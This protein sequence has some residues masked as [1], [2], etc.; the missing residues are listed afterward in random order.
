M[1]TRNASIDNLR[2]LLI[3]LVV[4]GHVFLGLELF[5][6]EGIIG[7]VRVVGTKII[8]GFHMPAFFALSGFFFRSKAFS[9]IHELWKVIRHKLITLGI[10]YVLCSIAYWG[11]KYVLSNYLDTPVTIQQ[12]LHIFTQP[13]EMMWYLYTLLIICVF[14]EIIDCFIKNKYVLFLIFTVVYY[15]MVL[16]VNHE[17]GQH[18][19]ENLVFFYLGCIISQNKELVSRW[20]IL[21]I[22]MLVAVISFY[23]YLP[24]EAFTLRFVVAC[25][26]TIF[27]VGVFQLNQRPIPILHS[28]GEYSMPIYIMHISFVGGARIILN[29][30]G[31]TN[32]LIH[33]ILGFAFGSF[34]CYFLYKCVIRKIKIFDF[35]F[36]PGKYIENS[37]TKFTVVK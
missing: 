9:N 13:I 28:M 8:Y 31:V 21:V 22:T 6:S 35:F 16:R 17:L 19:L 11:I 34:V 25:S 2:G 27:L 24:N 20:Y 4:L 15:T 26:V 18:I 10:P 5:P 14:A 3:L 37:K 30:L 29:H 12:V 32:Q 33:I 36:Y 1:K 7:N 23:F